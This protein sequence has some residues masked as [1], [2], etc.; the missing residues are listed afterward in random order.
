MAA[1]IHPQTTQKHIPHAKAKPPET[2]MHCCTTTELFLAFYCTAKGLTGAESGCKMHASLRMLNTV[3]QKQT[4][5][6]ATRS[7]TRSTWPKTWRQT[8]LLHLQQS[9]LDCM[10]VPGR[11]QPHAIACRSQT[12][13]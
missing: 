2:C 7:T 13:V 1:K 4:N 10:K 8:Q 12:D 5:F 3:Q 9:V 6:E 11:I